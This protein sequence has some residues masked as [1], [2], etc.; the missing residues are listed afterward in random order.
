MH[1]DGVADEE[2]RKDC[3]RKH[4]PHEDE[5]FTFLALR[6][7]GAG[8]RM[9]E[10]PLEG[11]FRLPHPCLEHDVPI[12]IEVAGESICPALSAVVKPTLEIAEAR[13]Q[14]RRKQQ[15]PQQ[16]AQRVTAPHVHELVADDELQ[17][18][19][20]ELFDEAARN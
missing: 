4:R 14:Q 15:M 1:E 11:V 20:T 18:L 6:R 13:D 12:A 2:R 17:V 3:G 8:V 16:A 7:Q 19:R 10:R 5:R 9:S